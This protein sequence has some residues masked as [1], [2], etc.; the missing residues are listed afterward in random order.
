MAIGKKTGGRAK[1]TPNAKTA[2]RK[3]E[4]AAGGELPLDY[5]LRVMRDPSV[6]H[7]RR[8]DM[9]GRAAPYVHARL[10][11]TTISGDKNNPIIQRIESVIVDPANPNSSGIRPAPE[12][13]SV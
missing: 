3:A 5:M 6:E 2:E 10:N 4:I 1:G 9:A 12:P 7:T 13:G 8:D 11:A